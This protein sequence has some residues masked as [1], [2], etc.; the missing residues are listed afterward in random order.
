MVSALLWASKPSAQPEKA[1]HEK[2][3]DDGAY[4]PDDSV[5]GGC[6]LVAQV[7]SKRRKPAHIGLAPQDPI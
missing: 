7:G 1:E 6:P 4:E 2:D 3:D 5:H